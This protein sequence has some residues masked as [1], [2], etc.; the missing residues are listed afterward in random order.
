VF[1][2]FYRSS[3][4]VLK[5]ASVHSRKFSMSVKVSEVDEKGTKIGV[6][7]GEKD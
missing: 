5:E 3:I 7:G 4:L 6:V 1:I 2:L